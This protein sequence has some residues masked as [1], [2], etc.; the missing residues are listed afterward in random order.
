MTDTAVPLLWSGELPTTLAFYR[1]LGYTV[2]Y[3]QTRP[4]VYG[5]VEGHGC[6]LH[7]AAAPP[8]VTLPTEH[9][10]RKSVV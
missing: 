1:A 5:A 9:V 8:G 7:F 4:Y 6:A 2:I 3:E 10:D